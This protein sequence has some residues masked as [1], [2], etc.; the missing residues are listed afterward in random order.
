MTK[1]TNLLYKIQDNPS[2]VAAG[3]SSFPSNVL[4]IVVTQDPYPWMM[5]VCNDRPLEL[6]LSD[7]GRNT[8]C[9]KLLNEQDHPIGVTVRFQDD[10]D[11][12]TTQRSRS[13]ESLA[14]L[15]NEWHQPPPSSS[16]SL[17]PILW[18]RSEDL[19]LHTQDVVTPVCSC[20][21]GRV[22]DPFRNKAHMDPVPSSLFEGYTL[23]LL[24][25]AVRQLNTTLL[26][27]LHYYGVSGHPQQQP[28]SSSSSSSWWQR[29]H[30]NP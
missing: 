16:S 7:N 30:R 18:I 9:P 6:E 26:D 4:P 8:P 5:D 13:F 27:S 20:L 25:Y 21:G 2:S 28:K 3:I 19:L 11:S 10:S 14:N 1:G 22:H 12:T 23:D 15:W 24:Q 29:I 17:R